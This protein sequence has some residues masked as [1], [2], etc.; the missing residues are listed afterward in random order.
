MATLMQTR[1]HG[2]GTATATGTPSTRP[3][4]SI[5]TTSRLRMTRMHYPGTV[6][7]ADGHAGRRAAAGP[8]R[9]AEPHAGQI[10]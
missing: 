6:P 9:Q 3:T 4:P 8:G 2:Q 1:P 7:S 10:R 5:P